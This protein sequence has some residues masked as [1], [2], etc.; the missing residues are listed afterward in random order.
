MKKRLPSLLALRA[1]QVAG[2]QPM[3]IPVLKKTTSGVLI[4]SMALCH[5]QKTGQDIAHP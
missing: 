1:F 4:H 5:L 2:K 3:I